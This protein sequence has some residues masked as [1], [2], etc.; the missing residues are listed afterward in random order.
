[1]NTD[2]SHEFNDLR[3]WKAEIGFRI[4]SLRENPPLAYTRRDLVAVLNRMY[5]FRISESQVEKIET[6]KSFPGY[7]LLRLLQAHFGTDYNFLMGMEVGPDSEYPNVFAYSEFRNYW[8]CMQ[9][10][11]VH[12]R[13]ILLSMRR[14]VDN[15]RLIAEGVSPSLIL[16]EY[17]QGNRPLRDRSIGQNDH[18]MAP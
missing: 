12:E 14:A 1:M 18:A 17:P 16:A 4:R 5:S 13:D 11:G 2:H 7:G 3:S 9:K 8:Y 6:G 10:A 15:F